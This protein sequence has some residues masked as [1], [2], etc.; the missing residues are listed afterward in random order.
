MQTTQDSTKENSSKVVVPQIP[1]SRQQK[2]HIMR[3]LAA[4]ALTKL[5]NAPRRDRRIM[6]RVYANAAYLHHYGL[7]PEDTGRYSKYT[8]NKDIVN[9]VSKQYDVYVGSMVKK[10]EETP[11]IVKPTEEEV[12]EVN[13]GNDIQM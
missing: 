12:A 10:V 4:F 1:N 9:W 13:R 8:P 6:A 2:R 7:Y 5:V 11:A 3:K